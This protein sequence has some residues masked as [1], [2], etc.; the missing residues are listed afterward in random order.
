MTEYRRAY[1]SGA[2]RFFT[3]N[4][5]KRKGKRVL[6]S[7]IHE[8]RRAFGTSGEKHPFRSDVVVILPDHLHCIWTLPPG[9]T[10]CSMRWN[11]LKG[12]FSRAI[13][14]GERISQSR[15]KR[16]ERGLWQRTSIMGA[17]AVRS[18]RFQQPRR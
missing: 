13:E 5:A 17:P 8:L 1:V 12:H 10:D 4:L 6:V 11:M 14:K 9:D 16:R 7:H 15:E 3:V 2:T 18:G